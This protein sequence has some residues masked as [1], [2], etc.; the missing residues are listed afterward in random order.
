MK[1]FRRI[2]RIDTR[3]GV[4]LSLISTNL[5]CIT[6]TSYWTRCRL[7]SPASRLFTQPFIQAQNKENIKAPRHRTWWGEFTD[8]WW[9]H[10]TKPSNTDD[11]SI[12]WRHHGHCSMQSRTIHNKS[13]LLLNS[14]PPEQNSSHFADGIFDRIFRHWRLFLSIQLTISQATS[15]YLNQCGPSSLT[16]IRGTRSQWVNDPLKNRVRGFIPDTHLRRH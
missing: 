10:R 14:F 11:V 2:I 4:I 7:K 13:N 9:I 5:Q 15:H 12:W 6:M 16:H 8:D 1:Q 3:W